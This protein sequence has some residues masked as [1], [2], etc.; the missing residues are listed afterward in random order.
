MIETL[1]GVEGRLDAYVTNWQRGRDKVP[2]AIKSSI[3]TQI[4]RTGSIDTTRFIRALDFREENLSGDGY[5]FLIDGARD[6]KETYDGF[7]EF[8]GETRRF[9]GRFN[10]RDGIS[11]A[12]LESVSDEIAD[13]SFAR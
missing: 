1:K 8:D 10:F 12:D 11:N 7:L 6:S 9:T 2:A 5:R 13:E 4:I 3:I